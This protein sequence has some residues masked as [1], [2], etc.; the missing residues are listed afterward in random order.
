MSKEFLIIGERIN[1]TRKSINKAIEK[2]DTEL[3]SKE[4]RKQVE[5]GAVY[6]DVNAGTRVTTEAE[7]LVW[8]V[9]TVQE[10]VE[11]P[12]CIDSP[13]PEAVRQALQAHKGRAIVNSIT[14]EQSRL[15]GILPLVEQFESDVVGLLMGEG[16]P[17]TSASER[18]RIAEKIVRRLEAES[19]GLGRLYFDPGVYS[20]ATDG[21]AGKAVLETLR[22][23]KSSYPE[24]KLIC[25]VSNV[26]FGLPS[27]KL[28][29]RTFLSM[30]I[31]AGL[32]GA[33]I[34]PTDVGIRSTLYAS[35][36][37]C[38][39]DGFCTDYIMAYREGKL[40]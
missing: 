36:A 13:N 12:C 10:A 34:D 21:G 26:S 3:I 14:A 20:V 24:A 30:L 16:S 25:G 40:E 38:G 31:E 33:I 4:A 2:R 6:V 29:N 35:R 19:V 22:E 7:D 11:A 37:L 23:L 5:C 32:D 1:A 27:R 15:E 17:P 39:V 8:L 18:L 28:L 9:R